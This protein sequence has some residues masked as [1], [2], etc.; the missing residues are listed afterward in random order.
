MYSLASINSL[1]D[2]L[3]IAAPAGPR[4][5]VERLYEEARDD[6]YGYCLTFGLTAGEAQEAAQDVFL[7][8]YEVMRRGEA[9]ENPRAWIFRVAHN[10]S[11]KLRARQPVPL[12]VD[13]DPGARVAMDADTPEQM[14][15]EQQRTRRVQLA[16]GSLSE[17]QR[18]CLMLR[19]EGLRY[20]EIAGV[21]GISASSVGEFLRR[22]IHRLKKAGQGAGPGGGHGRGGGHE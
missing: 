22:A 10:H 21:M 19:M 5:L 11:L 6:V 18:R 9:I 7:R 8:L 17:Q 14:A 12:P 1:S 15:M 4:E 2:P 13:F 3:R 16:I 20:P